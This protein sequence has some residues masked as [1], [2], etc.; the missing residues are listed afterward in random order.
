MK[1]REVSL[2]NLKN[3]YVFGKDKIY[4]QSM[5]NKPPEDI[6]GNVQQA[7]ELENLGCDIV[8]VAIPNM[9]A[10]KLISAIKDNISIPL[11][12]D[13][14]FDYKL[15]IES[16]NAGV[17]KIRINPGNIGDE[18]KIKQVISACKKASIPIRIGVNSG[19]LEKDILEK[20]SLSTPKA[21]DESALNNV[22]LL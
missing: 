8:R 1:K 20:Y 18:Y 10:I 16:V 11:V 12:A 21:L 17:D 3:G 6:N 4:V 22:N 13:I 15:A 19:S 5:L 2:V 7:K 14:H 9:D